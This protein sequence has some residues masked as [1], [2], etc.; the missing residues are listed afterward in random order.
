M[1]T[2]RDGPRRKITAAAALRAMI[3][4][5]RAAARLALMA[6]WRLVARPRNLV[7]PIP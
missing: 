5:T 1:R 3:A 7:Q 4:S 6:T 2:R